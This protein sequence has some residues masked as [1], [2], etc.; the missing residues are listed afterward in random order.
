M[1]IPPLA[2]EVPESKSWGECSWEIPSVLLL[3]FPPHLQLATF[4]ERLVLWL[5]LLTKRIVVFKSQLWL[6][7][8]F[9]R[10]QSHLDKLHT[11]RPQTCIEGWWLNFCYTFISTE[12]DPSPMFAHFD[13]TK[14]ALLS[15]GTE[16]DFV[17][18]SS[19]L[20]LNSPRECEDSSSSCLRGC[21]CV[22]ARR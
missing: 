22:A 11:F 16:E 17:F 4:R 9:V 8:L 21:G 6:F 7:A 1:Q 5:A 13:Q 20:Y 3:Y 14:R 12:H 2:L 10:G 18:S 19:S 15:S